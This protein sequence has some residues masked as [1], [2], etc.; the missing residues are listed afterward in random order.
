MTDLTKIKADN[1]FIRNAL[2]AAIRIGILLVLILWCFDIVRPFITIVLW[3]VIIAIA[4]SPVFALF[5][6]AA[7]I[8]ASGMIRGLSP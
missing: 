6:G 3:G 7:F 2:E 1:Q 5:G 4:I 8:F